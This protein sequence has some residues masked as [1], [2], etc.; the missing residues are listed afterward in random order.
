MLLEPSHK[1]KVNKLR[2]S[3]LRRTIVKQNLLIS[4]LAEEIKYLKSPLHLYNLIEGIQGNYSILLNPPHTIVKG[5]DKG[6]SEEYTVKATDIICIKS[7]VEKSKIKEIHLRK[8]LKN[9]RGDP[10]TTKLIKINKEKTIPII[11]K[12]IE[13]A[14]VYLASVSQSE[15]VNIDLYD[16]VDDHLVL[17][18]KSCKVKSCQKI[19]IIK[20]YKADFQAKKE[21]LERIRIFHKTDFYSILGF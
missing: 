3:F 7:S 6:M 20:K 17:K 14:Q 9:R 18:L 21:A 11:C 4:T 15:A 10:K 13:S 5:S 12:E 8:L 16:L 1:D 2:L 19:K